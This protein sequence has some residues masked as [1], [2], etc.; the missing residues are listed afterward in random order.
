MILIMTIEVRIVLAYV[1]L[2]KE[3][4]GTLHSNVG[5]IQQ[6][7]LADSMCRSKIVQTGF[8]DSS[9][10]PRFLTQNLICLT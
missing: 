9:I 6:V 8:Q 4:I 5:V 7:S 10:S 1:V 2:V 3:G